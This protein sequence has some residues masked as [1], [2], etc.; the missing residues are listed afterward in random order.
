MTEWFVELSGENVELAREELRG[1]VEALGG[2]RASD[3]GPLPR[4]ESVDLR[5]E[6]QAAELADRLALS[7][8]VIRPW[9]RGP[10]A[11]TLARL[12]REAAKGPSAASFRPVGR[13]TSSGRGGSLDPW[14]RSWKRGGGRVDLVRP[15]RR[16]LVAGAG[17][18][19]WLLGEEFRS[20]DRRRLEGRRMPNLP[21]Q[22]PVSLKPKL[23]R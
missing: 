12:E 3:P 8:R 6:G 21:F 4:L 1:A 11:P 22:R 19:A 5:G 20:V 9:P 16:F 14:V 18:G 7:R 2:P 15:D 17:D 10:E 23:A 13:P